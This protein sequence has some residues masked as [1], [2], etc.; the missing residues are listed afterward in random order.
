MPTAETIAIKGG[1]MAA[2][3][4]LVAELIIFNDPM[5]QQLAI[6]GAIVS[7]S[8][9]LHEIWHDDTKKSIGSAFAEVLKGI[10]LGFLAIPFW[11]LLLDAMGGQIIHKLFEIQTENKIE[12]S[13]WLMVAFGLSWYTVPIYNWIG[14]V[15]SL[16]AKKVSK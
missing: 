10:V 8:G 5:Y 1:A 2:T 3:G 6:V 12:S 4:G 14:R 11:Y 15:V 16:K 9:V 7:A 13:V